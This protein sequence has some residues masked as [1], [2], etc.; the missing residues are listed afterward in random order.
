MT[1]SYLNHHGIK[2]MKWGV[3]RYQNKDG[4]LTKAGQKRYQKEL[5]NLKKEKK[6]LSNQ[7]KTAAKL[8]KLDKLRKEIDDEKESLKKKSTDIDDVEESKKTENKKESIKDM[9]DADL[10]RVVNRMNNEK[11]YY[12]LTDDD[13]SPNKKLKELAEQKRLQKEILE[14]DETISKLSKQDIST[15]RKIVKSIFED[16][17]F[18][19]AKTAGK[20]VLTSQLKKVGKGLFDD[21][22]VK[23]VKDTVDNATKDTRKD[24]KKSSEKS[25][26]DE[27]SKED[28]KVYTGT[29][30]GK[31]TSSYKRSNN[32]TMYDVKYYD[33]V[34]DDNMRIGQNYIYGLLEDKRR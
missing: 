23:T 31:G 1:T 13:N 21:K 14:Y 6:V 25:K 30:E 34:S 4:T 9:S 32:S 20:D 3:R 22:T 2:G 8:E 28:K 33:F 16:V 24:F 11:R 7:K 18:P 15:G 12:E 5:D 27:E 19:A 26:K 17:L 29:V 10:A